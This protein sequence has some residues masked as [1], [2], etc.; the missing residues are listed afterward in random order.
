MSACECSEKEVCVFCVA[1]KVD[2]IRA[3]AAD[4]T[5]LELAEAWRERGLVGFADKG[6]YAWALQLPLSHNE[7]TPPPVKDIAAALRSLLQG[8]GK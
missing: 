7:R 8:G 5:I 6:S 3:E 4:Q 2:V 1:G